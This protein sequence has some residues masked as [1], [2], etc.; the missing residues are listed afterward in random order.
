MV[1]SP[2][3]GGAHLGG[4]GFQ[5]RLPAPGDLLVQRR[6]GG[7]LRL[8]RGHLAEHEHAIGP[9]RG[10]IHRDERLAIPAQPFR[11]DAQPPQ[12]QPL[13]LAPRLKMRNTALREPPPGRAAPAD[14]GC[15]AE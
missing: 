2:A 6:R 10:L 13:Q 11:G 15:N 4:A 1:S 5:E 14:Q 7:D 9:R 12:V 3:D 8:Q